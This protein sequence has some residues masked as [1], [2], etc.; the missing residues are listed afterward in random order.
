M[1]LPAKR[2]RRENPRWGALSIIA[3]VS[4]PGGALHAAAGDDL[5]QQEE[6]SFKEVC[7]KCH[8]LAVVTGSSLSYDGWLDVVKRMLERGA[9]ATDEQLSDVIDYLHRTQTSIDVN[10]A[11]PDELALILNSNAAAAEVVARRS[12]KRFSDLDDLK[13]VPGIDSNLIEK[14]SK[15]LYFQ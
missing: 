9:K 8:N 3:A 11:G 5:L 13:T 6:K 15:L 2:R 10:S 1:T 7:A 12:I 14:K 4:F